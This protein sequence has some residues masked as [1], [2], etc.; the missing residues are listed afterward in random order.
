MTQMCLLLGKHKYYFQG[1]GGV[2]TSVYSSVD[3][4]LIFRTW[5]VHYRQPFYV[6]SSPYTTIVVL[7]PLC[8]FFALL[9]LPNSYPECTW[10]G[11]GTQTHLAPDPST[12]RGTGLMLGCGGGWGRWAFL[13]GHR[14]CTHSLMTH[15]SAVKCMGSPLSVKPRAKAPD[16][17]GY[18]TAEVKR[19]EG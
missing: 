16:T 2:H 17:S 7:F 5:W 10:G 8:S 11:A 12:E 18:F 1:G 4:L 13:L 3:A 9:A 15:Q 6:G 14:K 19:F